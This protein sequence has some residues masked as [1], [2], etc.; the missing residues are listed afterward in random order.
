MVR[1]ERSWRGIT[2]P[3]FVVWRDGNFRVNLR[4]SLFNNHFKLS[5]LSSK[6]RCHRLPIVTTV[7]EKPL[8]NLSRYVT[9]SLFSSKPLSKDPKVVKTRGRLSSSEDTK[10]EETGRVNLRH[11]RRLRVFIVT[12]KDQRNDLESPCLKLWF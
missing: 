7:T 12:T 8:E 6:I 9:I 2:Y 3:T 10:S 11:L 5:V 4:R 1:T